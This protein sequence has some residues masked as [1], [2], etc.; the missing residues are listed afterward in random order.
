MQIKTNQVYFTS[1]TLSSS[2]LTFSD[3]IQCMFSKSRMQ[4][5]LFLISRGKIRCSTRSYACK[6]C[7]TS[8]SGLRCVHPTTG[9]CHHQHISSSYQRTQIM[10]SS[11]H[12][13]IP[14]FKNMDDKKWNRKVT[15]TQFSKA[16]HK[17]LLTF[18]VSVLDTYPDDVDQKRKTVVAIH[19]IPGASDDF[20]SLAAKLFEKGIRLVAP[21]SLGM[22]LL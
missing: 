15:I 20:E 4:I 8:A 22:L 2:F 13:G 3:F 12:T 19:G 6:S 9:H 16:D 14:L 17:K 7:V 18:D 21:T 10:K 1:L 11:T 5:I